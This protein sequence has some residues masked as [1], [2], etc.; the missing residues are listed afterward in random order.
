MSKCAGC[1]AKLQFTDPNEVG[2]IKDIEDT[3]CNRCFQI[4]NYNKYNVVNIDN[5]EFVSVLKEI[6]KTN[7][8]VLLV[9]DSL[10]LSDNFDIFKE[11]L[12]N[13]KILLVITKADLLPTTNYNKIFKYF[14]K[15]NIKFVNK[16]M[17]SSKNNHNLDLLIE[18]IYRYKNNNSVYV[19]GYTNAGKSTLINKLIYNYFDNKVT[20]TTSGL[21][22]TTLD[23][24]TIKLNK[25]LTII[26]TPGILESNN[27]IDNIDIEKIKLL[28]SKSKL[29]P[30][31]YQIKDSNTIMVDELLK[32]NITNNNITLYFSDQLKIQR[33]KKDIQ[34]NLEE[35]IIEVN[36]KEEVVISGLGFLK[37]M[38]NG[39]IKISTIPNTKIY[40]RDALM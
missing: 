13:N 9:V 19:V 2:Y 37:V 28:T 18:M 26:D 25:D 29:K 39:V 15:Y 7:S 3:L 24:I 27:I 22:S 8:L 1:G 31:T 30:I 5:K 16:I 11:L 33:Y 34:T 21:P 36:S 10:N 12:V 14:D 20:I 6:N 32:I 4:K 40:K 17:V 23:K 38:K 35:H